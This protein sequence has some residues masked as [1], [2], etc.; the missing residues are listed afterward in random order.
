MFFLL[1]FPLF[2]LLNSLLAYHVA[3]S[4]GPH[5][6]D[7]LVGRHPV[8]VVAIVVRHDG[9]VFRVQDQSCDRDAA[10]GYAGLHDSVWGEI[11]TNTCKRRVKKGA[12]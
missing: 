4:H 6:D 11:Y 12:S 10:D 3:S 1:T 9:V 7:V 5:A 8:P 2:S